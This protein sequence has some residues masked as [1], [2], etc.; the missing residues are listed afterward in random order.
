MKKTLIVLASSLLLATLAFS[1]NAQ[2][3]SEFPPLDVSPMDVSYFPANYPSMH[4][5]GT[6][7]EPLVMRVFYSR[8]QVKGRVIFG[9]LVPYNEVWRLGANE[10][11]ELD[12]FRPVTIAGHRL[13]PG[14]Y[15]LYAIPHEKTWTMIVNKDTDIW[16]EFGY[17]QSQDILRTDVPSSS[18][19]HPQEALAIVF[20][21]APHGADMVVAWDKTEVSLPISF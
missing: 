10:A 5:K 1:A 18:L 11:T 21:K 9:K 13:Q 3:K 2:M 17:K 4:V 14:R 19:V 8:P 12:L 6:P 7:P 15:T 16:G 20:R